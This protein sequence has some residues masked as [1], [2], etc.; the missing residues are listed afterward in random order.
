[1]EE[2]SNGVME[3]WRNGGIRCDGKK[4]VI[5]VVICRGVLVK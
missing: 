2:W 5:R 3:E 4:G 1:M